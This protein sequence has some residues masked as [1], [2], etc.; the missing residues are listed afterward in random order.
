MSREENRKMISAYEKMLQDGTAFKKVDTS[1]LSEP[2]LAVAT[3]QINDSPLGDPIAA[4]RSPSSPIVED[5]GYGQFDSLM[6]KRMHELRASG[7]K[8]S[9][10]EFLNLK[11]RVKRL[12]EAITLVMETQTKLIEGR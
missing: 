7:N 2:D 1:M 9:N 11:K 3:G 12:E 10:N 5:D 8:H 6:E 4:N